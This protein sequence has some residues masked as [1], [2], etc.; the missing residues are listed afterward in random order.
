MKRPYFN[1]KVEHLKISQV[2]VAD[3]SSIY[4]AD[5]NP[6]LPLFLWPDQFNYGYRLHLVSGGFEHYR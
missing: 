5:G 4:L 1:A 2:I 3:S 6:S